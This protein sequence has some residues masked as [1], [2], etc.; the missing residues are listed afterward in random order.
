[1]WAVVESCAVSNA[2]RVVMTRLSDEM[3]FQPR[4]GP[5]EWGTWIPWDKCLPHGFK[6]QVR[7]LC[8]VKAGTHS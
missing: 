1:M 7:W 6:G 5:R 2:S 8:R 3:I 4:E